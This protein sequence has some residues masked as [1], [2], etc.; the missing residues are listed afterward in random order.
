[1]PDVP[2]VLIV[3]DLAE[4]ERAL[5]RS[6]RGKM[7]LLFALTLADGE[8]QFRENP[9]LAAIC[10]DGCVEHQTLD[11]LPLLALFRQS[12]TGPI[13]AIGSVSGDREQMMANGCSHEV[14]MK[15]KL[16]PLLITL[17]NL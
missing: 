16:V 3:D 12:F 14:D 7:Q 4:L 13:V 10:L 11:T 15:H 9:D 17:L 8:R 2:K 1:M 6:A 5:K